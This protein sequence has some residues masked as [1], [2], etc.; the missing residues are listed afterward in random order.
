MA[1]F[2]GAAPPEQRA[3]VARALIVRTGRIR[4]VLV[5]VLALA[6]TGLAIA[7]PGTFPATLTAL[8]VLAFAIDVA[9]TLVT[10][11]A[12][13]LGRPNVWS[14]RFAVQNATIAITAPLGN[15]VAGLDGAVAAI[16]FGAA[17]ALVCGVAAV[18]EPL[19]R[20]PR[21]T[22]LPDGTLRF[23]V[24]QGA[25]GVAIQLVQ[26][27]PIPVLFVLAGPTDAGNAAIALSI[28]LAGTHAVWQLSMVTLPALAATLSVAGA[29]ERAE[30]AT[31]V[32]AARTL[33]VVLPAAL[34][35]VLLAG[36]VVPALVGERYEAAVGALTLALA[37]LPLAPYT[38]AIGQCCA[39][40]LRP[41]L[42][43]VMAAVGAAVSLGLAGGL[44]TTVGAD[45]AAIAVVAGSAVS[46][47]VGAVALP[48]AIGRL[49]PAAALAGSAA[50][51]AV[52]LAIG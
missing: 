30:R 22:P 21:G 29:L 39:L 46:V 12:L 48:G 5:T 44:A 6:A 11:L 10:Q 45:A 35:G 52:A 20:A 9:A 49:G 26:R 42:R 7:A 13:G 2:I 41:G 33:A 31:R 8:T 38:G 51:F 32:L 19:R 14:L 36:P 18:R 4:I 47:V 27:G 3:G 1:R 24:L 28:A 43:A 16:A 17:L 37:G 50:T 34:V 15:A 25:A 23:A 40:R